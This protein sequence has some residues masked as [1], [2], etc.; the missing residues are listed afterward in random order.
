MARGP[1]LNYTPVAGSP[2]EAVPLS[3]EELLADGAMSRA[4]AVAFSGIGMTELQILIASGELP[5]FTHGRKRLIPRRGVVRWLA[6][7]FEAAK[8]SVS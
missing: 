8:E 5:S 2:V 3:P 1:A 4:D 6:Q 7:K